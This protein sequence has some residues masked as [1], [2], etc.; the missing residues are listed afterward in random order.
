MKPRS[1]P[2]RFDRHE[3]AGC[4]GDLGTDLPLIAAM[5]VAAQ[6]NSAGVLVVFGLLQVA[7]GL[8]YRMPMPVQPLKAMAALVI[9]QQADAATLYGGGL[10][11]GVLMLVLVVTGMLG[12]LARTIPRAVV[13]GVQFGLGIQLALIA[14]RNFI[15]PSG[16]MGYALAAVAFIVVVVL[17][18]HRRWPAGLIVIGLG[19]LY[20]A[21]FDLDWAKLIAGA[22]WQLPEPRLPQVADVWIGFL[23]LALPQLPL[24]L[25]NS[26]LATERLAA[27]YFPQ[28]APTVRKLGFTYSAMNL[29]APFFGGVPVCHG[30]GGMAGHY[31][32]GARTGGSVVIYGSCFIAAGLF[33]SGSFDQVVRL[34]PRAVLGVLLFFEGLA[35]L[36]RVRDAGLA[37]GEW[38]VVFVTGLC[39]VAL[40]Y[41]YLVGMVVGW[42]L[43]A[44]WMRR[45]DVLE[46]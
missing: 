37:R 40:P 44:W 35:L 18:G 14:G 38:L 9:A 36:R 20:A 34:F 24:S 30:S 42:A 21:L 39:A 19:L 22:G 41:G 2:I 23:V 28:R 46:T 33:F 31:A 7:T 12:W 15:G 8:I 16:A 45:A 26:L 6:L 43:H 10:A 17:W 11:I 4:C 25:G 13:R 32:F 1:P 5:I 3:W 29:V 27:D